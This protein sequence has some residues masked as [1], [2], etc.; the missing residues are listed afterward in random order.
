MRICLRDYICEDGDVLRITVNNSIQ[1]QE[2]LFNRG[3]CRDVTLNQGQNTISVL[4]VNGTGYK[5]NCDYADANSG[6]ISVVS[7]TRSGD[8]L[9]PYKFSKQTWK[10]RAKAGSQSTIHINVK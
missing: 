3:S 4:A 9:E 7:Y 5:G 6:E 2:E 8:G 1:W 10:L